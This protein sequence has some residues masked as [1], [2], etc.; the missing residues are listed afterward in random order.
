MRAP[1]RC[2][3]S[4]RIA[5]PRRN[6]E[7][8]HQR[9]QH[10]R[11]SAHGDGPHVG[12]HQAADKGHGQHGGK[13]GKSG[14]NG[15]VANFS[16]RLH[17]N[18]VA[19]TMLVLGQSEVAH[20][21]LDHHDGVVHQNADRKDQREERDAVDGVAEKIKHRHGKRQRDRN[22]QQ[23]HARLAPSQKERD[24]NGDRKRGQQQVLEQ[25]VGFGLGGFAVVAR[26]GHGHVAG[27]RHALHLDARA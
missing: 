4:S 6:H 12:P 22:G 9:K 27:N 10:G 25:F 17:G 16:H 24:Q 3:P 13:N 18:V 15:G 2:L 5:G 21:V 14:E 20:H 8:H 26:G 7:G 19:R 23:H 1:P 11:G